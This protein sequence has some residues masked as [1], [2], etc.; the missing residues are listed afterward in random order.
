MAVTAHVRFGQRCRW[1][2]A[3]VGIMTPGAAIVLGRVCRAFR[4]L[5]L[6]CA[7][8]GDRKIRRVLRVLDQAPGER[9]MGAVQECRAGFVL[10]IRLVYP[11]IRRIGYAGGISDPDGRSN[12][13]CLG[14]SE[15]LAGLC[16][17]GLGEQCWVGR[18]DIFPTVTLQAQCGR[19]FVFDIVAGHG[20]VTMRTIV[21]SRLVASF[22]LNTG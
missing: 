9:G 15:W 6:V 3:L 20:P 8:Q 17:R 18:G 22:A 14:S 16:C 13:R 1:G 10:E 12:S 11:S 5:T 19:G 4:E 21:P 2:R 7:R